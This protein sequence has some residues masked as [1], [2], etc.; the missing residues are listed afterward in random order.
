MTRI[1]RLGPVRAHA[2][3]GD[4]RRDVAA[5]G[6]PRLADSGTLAKG[7]RAIS[8]SSDA[9]PLDDIHNTRKIS[10][11]YLG[12]VKLDRDALLAK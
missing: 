4:R 2:V 12:G 1:A 9:N 6:A 11:V 10:A 8:S 7:K 3:A 5:G